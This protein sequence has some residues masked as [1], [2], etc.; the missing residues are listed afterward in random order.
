VRLAGVQARTRALGRALGGIGLAA[1][2]LL[3]G[4]FLATGRV[5]LAVAGAAI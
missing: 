4:V 5:P 2:Y 3:L 1:A